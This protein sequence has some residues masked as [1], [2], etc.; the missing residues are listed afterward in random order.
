MVQV[1][2]SLTINPDEPE[3]V[4]TYFETAMPLLEKVDAKVVQRLEL[5]TAVIGERPS[6]VVMLVDYP[7][8]EAVESVFN[9]PEYKA[10][11]PTRD[12]AFL[13]YN[14]CIVNKNELSG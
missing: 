4:E 7:S 1:V 2:A 3:A 13:K 12:K 14:V 8:Y 5:G 10:I 9:S 6:E 11:A